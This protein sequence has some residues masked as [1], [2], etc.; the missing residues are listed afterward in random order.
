[1]EF[2]RLLV[3][4]RGDSLG[5]RVGRERL[6]LFQLP[7]AVLCIRQRRDL[8]FDCEDV[9][10]CFRPIY[11]HFVECS[12]RGPGSSSASGQVQ[13]RVVIG[14]VLPRRGH[15]ARHFGLD[16]DHHVD[17]LNLFLFFLA[18]IK[19]RTPFFLCWGF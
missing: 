11:N 2:L 14:V 7:H 5:R 1:M 8:E 3:L 10:G 9:R 6:V 13:L 19:R 12:C 16:P 17:V 15:V 18:S 4:R